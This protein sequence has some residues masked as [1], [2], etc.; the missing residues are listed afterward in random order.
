MSAAGDLDLEAIK[1]LFALSRAASFELLPDGGTAA[2]QP[3][4]WRFRLRGE[5]LAA[6]A[7]LE[8]RALIELGDDAP[9]GTPRRIT[10]TAWGASWLKRWLAGRNVRMVRT[11]PAPE[12]R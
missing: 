2:N 12:D 8:A 4:G 6:L 7:A 3:E 11:A 5:A 1:A 10:V 9:D